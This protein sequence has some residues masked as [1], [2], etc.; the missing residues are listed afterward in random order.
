MKTSVEL[1]DEK[2]AIAKKLGETSTLKELLDKA[3][4]AFIAQARRD[5]MAGL[6]GTDFFSGD[7]KKMRKKN[8]SARR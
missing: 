4:D 5:S 1:D 2:I 8:V 6:L 7:L 3:L